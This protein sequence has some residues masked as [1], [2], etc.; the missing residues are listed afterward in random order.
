[1]STHHALVVGAR[2]IIGRGLLHGLAEEDGWRVTGCSRTVPNFE[3]DFE[4][5]TVDLTDPAD[6]DAALAAVPE[7]THVFFAAYQPRPVLSEEVA[8]N[9]KMLRNLVAALDTHCPRLQ[10]IV[11]Y[12]G[13]KVYGAH[14]GPFKTP[15]REDDPRYMPPHFYFAQEDFL[16]EAVRDRPR[17]CTFLRPDLMAGVA[18]GNPMN[19]ILAVGVFAAI[20]RELGLPLRFPGSQ[21]AYTVLMQMTDARLL[22]QASIWA[23][24]AP[25]AA[26]EAFNVTNGD[27]FRWKHLW[28]IVAEAFDM[29][30][31]P[32]Q[33][34]PLSEHM[35]DKSAVWTRIAEQN[36]LDTPPYAKLVGWGFADDILTS[37]YDIV[38][39]VG[40]IRR[41][42]F[43]GAVDTQKSLRRLL[44]S[45]RQHKILP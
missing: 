45:Y 6:C 32:P 31:G 19:I 2:G 1:M 11:H 29:E 34:L 7:T 38:S 43:H 5:L 30:V 44:G 13:L 20:S 18:T 15:A 26:G 39:D 24:T 9:L 22:A 33:P 27:L 23:A 12:Q 40:K 10:R 16:R 42:G 8:P 28:P 17:T 4:Y 35:R 21:R 3:G 14:L 25:Q 36:G 41:Y 37:G